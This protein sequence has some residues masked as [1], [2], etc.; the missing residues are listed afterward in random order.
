MSYLITILNEG[1]SA[2]F[3]LEDVLIRTAKIGP[4]GFEPATS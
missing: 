1:T 3:Y 4:A 2:I